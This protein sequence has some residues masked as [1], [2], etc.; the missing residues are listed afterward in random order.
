MEPDGTV[1]IKIIL[2]MYGL[3]HTG[4]IANELLEKCLNQHGYHKSKLVPGLWKQ[5]WQPICFTLVVNDF[6]ITYTGQEH[7]LHLKTAL[8]SYNAISTN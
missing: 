3:P 7:A 5:D 6:G 1:D 4:L 8:E 2:G